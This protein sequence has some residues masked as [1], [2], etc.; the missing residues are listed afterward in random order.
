MRRHDAS[1]AL[2]ALVLLAA[3]AGC[4]DN[5]AQQAPAASSA[6]SDATQQDV[7]QTQQAHPGEKIYKQ[8]C[9]SCHAAGLSGAPKL[10]DVENWAPRIAQG[11]DVLLARTIEGIPP[12]MPPRGLCMSCSDEELAQA[13]DYMVEQSR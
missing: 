6:D 3:L 2:A 12:A 13:I 1:A 9:F 8:A 7:A 10:G 5:T 4:S 11:D